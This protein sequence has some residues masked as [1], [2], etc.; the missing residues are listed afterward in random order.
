MLLSEPP[1]I[2]LILG[3]HHHQPFGNWD[4]VIEEAYTAAYRPFLDAVER[5]PGVRTTLHYTGFLLEWLLGRHPDFVDQLRRLVERGQVELLTGGYYAP[6]LA[7][8]PAEDQVAQ[9]CRLSEALHEHFGATPE[10]MWLAERIWE[11]HLARPLTEAGVHWTALDDSVFRAAGLRGAQLFGYYQTED[12]G[13]T[14]EVFPLN[15]ELS[16][17]LPYAAPE[18]VVEYL[19]AHASTDGNRVAFCL[20]DGEKFGVWPNS[21]KAVYEQGWLDRV[22]HLIEAQD[23]IVSTTVHDYRA[24]RRPFGRIYLPSGSY[25]QMQEWA[26]PPEEATAFAEARSKLEE[27]F[28]N[29][30]RGG[31]WRNFL[32]RYPESNNLHKKMLLVSEKVQAASHARLPVGAGA[33]SEAPDWQEARECLWQGQSNDPYWHGI[34]GGL[35][36]TH[37]RSA[38]YRALLTA[39]VLSDRLLHE[40]RPFLTVEERDFDCDGKPEI[41]VSSREQNLYFNLEG[42][43]LFELD[44]KP[45]RFNVLDTMARRHEAYHDKIARA[46]PL[47][48]FKRDGGIRAIYDVVLTKEAGLER[49]LYL[50]WYRRLSFLDHFLHPDSHLESFY[51]MSYGEQGDFVNQP[52]QQQLEVTPSEV[53]LTL[54]RDGHVWVG[55]DFRPIQVAKRFTMRRDTTRVGVDYEVTND[56]ERSVSLWFGV[57]FNANFLAGNAP[58]RYYYA[59]GVVIPDPRL[60]S[61][62]ELSHL[63]ALG[64]RDAFNGLAYQLSWSAPA[65]VWRFPVETVS[66]SEGG[67]ERVYQSSV[68]MPHW[69]LELEPKARYVLRFEQELSELAPPRE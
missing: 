17:M 69:R 52:Y 58:D 19:R 57:E 28:L 30:V 25:D 33:A 11:P 13:R 49:F 26:L 18:K 23:W 22:F 45:R 53:I 38:N 20:D 62:G 43:A 55:P 16:G 67:V 54:T 56:S 42:G 50:D 48:A 8:I 12:Q 31:M 47:E 35:Y 64:I 9:I 40:D 68:I 51:N 34:F 36:L 10:G 14:L 15:S 61:K 4:W 29:F 27:R 60:G 41:L 21:F 59:P 39:E 65:T 6:V 2:N 7:V 44:F 66:M 5:H 1:K 46:T 37:L 63:R 32:V 24:H 3:L